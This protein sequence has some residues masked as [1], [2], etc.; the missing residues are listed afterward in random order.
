MTDVAILVPRK[1]DYG[2]RD[3]LWAHCRPVWEK[4][5]PDWPIHEGHHDRGPFNRSAAINRAAAA[6]GDW[7]VAVI[8][9]SDVLPDPAA[10]REAVKVARTGRP[11]TGFSTRRNLSQGGTRRIMQGFKGSWEPLVRNEHPDCHSGAYCVSRE[12]W[13]RVGG[14]DELFVGW[15]FEDTA[16]QTACETVA[17]EKTYRAQAPLWHLYHAKSP[18]HDTRLPNFKRNNERRKRYHVAWMDVEAVDAL[19][20]EAKAAAAGAERPKSLTYTQKERAIAIPR[21]LHRTVP[22]KTSG[23]VDLWWEEAQELNPGWEYMDHREPLDPSGWPL[24]GDLWGSCGSGAQKAGLIRLEALH[25][26]GGVYLDSDVEPYSPLEPLLRLEGFAAWEDRYVVPDAVMGFRPGHPAV[27]LM[28]ERARASV[29][30]GEG[31]WDSGPGVSTSVLPGRDDVLLLPPGSFYPYHYRNKERDRA[32]DHAA[33][34]PWAFG[35]HHW[36]HSW[37]GRR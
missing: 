21:I 22:A 1:R 10:V 7:A 32:R 29:L 16:F 33:E 19:L 14:F 13:D 23:E 25:R 9:D 35:A 36:H 31:A 37:K 20:D 26:Y 3:R 17:G 24:T 4:M 8:I 11:A 15:G 27:S 5:F 6:A 28:I 12:L 30:R 18:E 2:H 34:Q